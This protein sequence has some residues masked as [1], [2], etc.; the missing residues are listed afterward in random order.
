MKKQANV[1]LV[2]ATSVLVIGMVANFA[3]QPKQNAAIASP[4]AE[5]TG[6]AANT[7]TAPEQLA[8]GGMSPDLTKINAVDFLDPV[9][10]G[11]K[12]PSFSVKDA[13]GKTVQ[14][15]QF[16][17][18]KNVVLVFYSGSFCPVC[19]HQLSNL[20]S[21]LKDFK[22]QD[23][24][25]IAVSADDPLHAQKTLGEHGLTFTIIPDAQ[26]TIIK[27]YGVS[28]VA[29]E[30]LAWPSSFIIDKSGV[31]RMSVADAHGKRL[32]SSDLLPKLSAITGKPAPK[33]DYEQ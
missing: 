2:L 14:L 6:Q 10:V 27:K 17:G 28:N 8:E 32:H 4:Q 20:Q 33:L 3:G 30:G 18:K 16:A 19:G 22:D 12:A 13:K 23:A 26:K 9:P 5:A 7:Q 29:K 15:S 1:G 25:I 21:H 31:V 24:E 11:Q